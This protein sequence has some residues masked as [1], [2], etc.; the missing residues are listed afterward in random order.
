MIAL[1]LVLALAIVVAAFVLDVCAARHAERERQRLIAEALAA[2]VFSQVAEAEVAEAQVNRAR[3]AGEHL[4]REF[5]AQQRRQRR[6]AWALW[7][8][9]T[10]ARERAAFEHSLD[11]VLS[12]HGITPA[13]EVR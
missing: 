3:N 6:E 8:A 2:P 13:R 4:S 1:M 5:D 7:M 11:A 12:E 9:H 10:T